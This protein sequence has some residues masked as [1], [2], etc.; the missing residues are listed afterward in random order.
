MAPPKVANPR[1]SARYY[2]DNPDARA[3][4]AKT[5]TKVNARPE[6]RAKRSELATARRER[7]LMGK[8]GP[9]LSHTKEG[10]LVRENPS[11]NRARNRGLK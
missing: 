8:G 5:D 9:D 11:T 1:S 3:S 7:G 10:T 6:Q 4:K 2:R